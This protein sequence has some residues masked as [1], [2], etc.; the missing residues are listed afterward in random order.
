MR[1]IGW[2]GAGVGREWISCDNISKMI[3]VVRNVDNW[4]RFG[5]VIERYAHVGVYAGSLAD[6]GSS[7]RKTSAPS[8]PRPGTMIDQDIEKRETDGAA[9][10][11]RTHDPV[12]TNLVVV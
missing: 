9:W 10:G 7:P 4:V 12:I 2:T 8:S 5:K 6:V 11:T 3:A 1:A